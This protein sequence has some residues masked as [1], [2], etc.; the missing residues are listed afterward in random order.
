MPALRCLHPSA[1]FQQ[2]PGTEAD[3]APSDLTPPKECESGRFASD[4]PLGTRPRQ[5]H[6][7]CVGPGGQRRPNGRDMLRAHPAPQRGE[8]EIARQGSGGGSKRQGTKR[9]F[10][11]HRERKV[12]RVLEKG[13]I[14]CTKSGVRKIVKTMLKRVKQKPNVSRKKVRTAPKRLIWGAQKVAFSRTLPFQQPD[15]FV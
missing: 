9:R 12:Q 15:I 11:K 4:S 2:H 3:S 1:F 7:R 6:M 8:R 14:M 5:I 10:P 13:Q